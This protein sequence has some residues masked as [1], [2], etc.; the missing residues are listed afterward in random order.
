MFKNET[1][2]G[3]SESGTPCGERSFHQRQVDTI[4]FLFGKLWPQGFAGQTRR[5][6]HSHVHFTFN[7]LSICS[8][9]ARWLQLDLP[10]VFWTSA[11]HHRPALGHDES[12]CWTKFPL[13]PVERNMP[14]TDWCVLCSDS[15]NQ[16]MRS[17]SDVQ[18][19]CYLR[20]SANLFSSARSHCL[21]QLFNRKPAKLL[22][23]SL[24]SQL[25]LEY[26]NL[27]KCWTKLSYTGL[28]CSRNG[29]T[30]FFLFLFYHNL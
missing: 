1:Q 3:H 22:S 27:E 6:C 29:Y 24:A 23:V 30:V 14:S 13:K 17:R 28:V 16:K 21:V 7:R 12:L 26:L 11:V 19:R 20:I 8:C 15:W 10:L 25:L 18:K 9:F 5:W 2:R 4:S